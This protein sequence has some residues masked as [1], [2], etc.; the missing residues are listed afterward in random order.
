MR[1]KGILGGKIANAI[2]I[3]QEALHL[4]LKP[5]MMLIM[6]LMKSNQKL[7]VIENAGALLRPL[8]NCALSGFCLRTMRHASNPSQRVDS[9]N[10]LN[11]F[12][13]LSEALTVSI[14][15]TKRL[16]RSFWIYG[17]NR[18]IN[19]WHKYDMIACRGLIV[20]G[21]VKLNQSHDPR[22]IEL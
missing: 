16:L 11:S 12:I 20:E 19:I 22:S 4:A 7:S 13:I 2:D 8:G 14:L 18:Q 9:S 10:S 1:D 6:F 5:V 15:K 21:R 17:F 3:H